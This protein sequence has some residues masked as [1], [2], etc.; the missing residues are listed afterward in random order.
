M[1]AT[2]AE[3]NMRLLISRDLL[4]GRS[5][6]GSNLS[7]WSFAA[8]AKVVRAQAEP[9]AKL[10]RKTM[11]IKIM[12]G[13]HGGGERPRNRLCLSVI[14]AWRASDRWRSFSAPLGHEAISPIG[15][16]TPSRAIPTP[17]AA[18]SIHLSTEMLNA[19]EVT[20][21]HCVTTILPG[22]EVGDVRPFS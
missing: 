14:R 4:R 18:R 15:H 20:T 21:Q 9:L 5:L 13:C 12:K 1:N 3:Q 11:S 2:K 6:G 19:F 16:S 10:N 22:L 8:A 7:C 17:T